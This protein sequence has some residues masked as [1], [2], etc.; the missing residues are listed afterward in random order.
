MSSENS[1]K[2]TRNNTNILIIIYL[3]T[4]ISTDWIRKKSKKKFGHEN[5]NQIFDMALINWK[6]DFTNIVFMET[7]LP[8]GNSLTSL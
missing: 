8:I 6:T 4:Q 1:V 3:K 5:Q 7:N 2:R